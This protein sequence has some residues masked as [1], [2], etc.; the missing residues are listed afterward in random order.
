MNL[1]EAA[2][3]ALE[4]FT[5]LLTFNPTHNEYAKGREAVAA[6]R[7]ALAQ[8]QEP[9]AWQAVGGSIWGHKTSEDDRPLY[10]ED[11]NAWN[12]GYKHGLWQGQN[13]AQPMSQH[14]KEYNDSSMA[15]Y[16]NDY[17]KEQAAMQVA[18]PVPDAV[19]VASDVLISAMFQHQQEDNDASMAF[20]FSDYRSGF[21][22]AERHYAAAHPQP[23]PQPLTDERIL[24]IAK[25]IP[26]LETCEQEWLHFA[27]RL[28]F[29]AGIVPAPTTGE[30]P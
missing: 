2:E 24:N 9:V 23:A 15:F 20:D 22:A 18:Q 7:A 3:K 26:P 12:E 21:R 25:T 19:P 27:H 30:Q 5:G 14:Q 11:R 29:A 8:K 4:A 1:R 13:C 10:T 17:R 6:L 16:F 28:L